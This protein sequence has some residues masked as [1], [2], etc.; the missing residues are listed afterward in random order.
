MR[1]PLPPPVAGFGL[2]SASPSIGATQRACL[3]RGLSFVLILTLA[4]AVLVYAPWGGRDGGV[5]APSAVI[6]LP[7]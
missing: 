6:R 5:P 3:G 1:M 2:T 7:R 4:C